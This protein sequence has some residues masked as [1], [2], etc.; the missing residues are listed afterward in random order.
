MF[1][2]GISSNHRAL[3]IN[4]PG[5]TLGLSEAYTPT[6]SNAWQLQCKDPWVVMTYLQK[7]SQQLSM[8]NLFSCAANLTVLIKPGWLTQDQ[9]Y[10]YKAIDQAA[11]MTRISAEC[12]CWKLK[13]GKAPWSPDLTTAIYWVLFWKGVLLCT[14]GHRVG[15]SVLQSQAKKEVSPILL[16]WFDSPW[17]QSRKSCKRCIVITICSKKTLTV[18]I[19][20]LDSWLKLR[21]KQLDRKRN[22]CGSKYKVGN[23]SD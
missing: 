3:W 15:S 17:R 1:D 5:V 20:G 18:E 13:M 14:N 21:P 23:T 16:M 12:Q 2:T 10:E 8:A 6:K 7:L 22:F 11:T 9:Q 4:L 19:L